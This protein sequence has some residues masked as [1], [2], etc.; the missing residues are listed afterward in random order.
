MFPGPPRSASRRMQVDRGGVLVRLK[1]AGV[2]AFAGEALS[3]GIVTRFVARQDP[4]RKRTVPPVGHRHGL[5][6]STISRR[7]DHS[8]RWR[9]S[10]REP[11]AI[12]NC[13]TRAVWSALAV[14]TR[15]PSGPNATAVTGARCS[16]RLRLQ[17]A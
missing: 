6:F 15:W 17:R 14:T 2:S 9:Q 3:L 7:T 8:A 10:S 1:L 4:M 5:W 12:G 11:E 16:R 13:Q